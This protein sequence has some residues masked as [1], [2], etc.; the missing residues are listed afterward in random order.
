MYT[1]ETQNTV[2]P[3]KQTDISTD[4]NKNQ[5]TPTTE[6]EIQ[7]THLNKDFMYQLMSVPTYSDAE[8]RLLTFIVLW[9][10][11]NNVEY[12]F[13]DYGNLYLTKGQI[14]ENE[15]YPCVTAHL[16][17]VQNQQELYAQAGQL[18]EVKTRKSGK[19]HEIYVD[20]MG[21]GGDDKA[22]VLICL[23]L[24]SHV[25][26][27]KACFFL[28]EE[29]G[30]KGSSN[31]NVKWF[32]NVGYVIGFDSPDLNRAAWSCCGTALF[33]AKFYTDKIQD[34]CKKNGVTN[35]KAEP[36]TDVRCIRQKTDIICM[37][38]G[39][40]YYNAHMANEYC[41]IEDMDAACRLGNELITH[42]GKNAYRMTDSKSCN[43]ELEKLFPSSYFYNNSNYNY[44]YN[45]K[46]NSSTKE[47][48]KNTT[49]NSQ[50][51]VYNLI[52]SVSD[53]YEAFISAMKEKAETKCK[54]LGVDFNEFK[55]IFDTTIK[56]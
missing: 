32:D 19:K 15:F 20:G 56:F 44:N 1:T 13:D 23:S 51:D 47:A 38:F 36:F 12:E 50:D 9:A 7:L 43:Q 46:N 28:S 21:I 18:L 42:L 40:G 49:K 26:T 5:V 11:K 45:N 54:E 31:L 16:D 14:G 24:F 8:Y 2:A 53:D 4:A 34:V 41:V 22:G 39:S 10:K 55:D 17:T 3:A 48:D 27:L 30:C 52:K 33:D 35:F 37:N 29:T 6:D 25:E